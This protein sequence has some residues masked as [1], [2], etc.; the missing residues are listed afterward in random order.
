MLLLPCIITTAGEDLQKND[1]YDMKITYIANIRI[2]TE[3]A[4]GYQIL[5]MCEAFVKAGH[6]VELV[7]PRRRN[8]EYANVDVF[9]H[10]GI[11]ERFPITRLFCLDFIT[12]NGHKYY[13]P[14]GFWI[15]GFSF[16]FSLLVFFL[17]RKTD[18][19][20]SRDAF[21][22]RFISFFKRKFIWEIHIPSKHH[23]KRLMINSVR[24]IVITQYVKNLLLRRGTD[25]NRIFVAPD[26][27]DM[28]LF[29]IAIDSKTAKTRVRL[30]LDKKIVLYAGQLFK[31]KGV[32][33]L[34][35][36]SIFMKDDTR[37]VIVG[38]TQDDISEM[39]KY[40]RENKLKNIIMVGQKKH[41][42]IPYYLKSADVLVLP[43]TGKEEVSNYYTSPMK[44]F[45]YMASRR[46]IVASKIPS[47]TEVLDDSMAIFV[48]PDDPKSLAWGIQYALEN[49]V[50]SKIESAY[51]QVRKFTWEK[52]AVKI[53]ENL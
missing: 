12:K 25:G 16:F 20:Y 11:Q 39:R 17:W 14:L 28:N 7:V 41:Q 27:V 30:P 9:E 6:D 10:Y 4:H 47:L 42:D 51:S 13:G 19:L 23:Y 43:N 45:E 31:W 38:G 26:A 32:N 2:P 44:L 15:Q 49:D 3:K 53:L 52:R 48:K 36:A 24:M 18:M 46:P 5:K 33:T 34:L 37:I 8:R 29:D 50:K 35:D 22:L 1:F 21:I 40:I